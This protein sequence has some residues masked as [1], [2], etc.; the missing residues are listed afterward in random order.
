MSTNKIRPLS[1]YE[2]SEEER[3]KKEVE[4]TAAQTTNPDIP[5]IWI[6]WLYDYIHKEVGEDEFEKRIKR[7]MYD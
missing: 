1:G 5:R 6:E 4:I 2:Y 7:K 3:A